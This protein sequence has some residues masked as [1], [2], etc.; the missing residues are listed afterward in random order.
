MK[1]SYTVFSFLL[2]SFA[3]VLTY[4]VTSSTATLAFAMFLLFVGSVFTLLISG[5]AHKLLAL[6]LFNIV[7][8][9]YVLLA[10][11]HYLG[12]EADWSLFTNE[13]LDEYKFY[14]KSEENKHLPIRAI[15]VDSFVQRTHLEYGGYV[16]YISLLSSIA[17][18]YFDGNHLLLQ[19][20]GTAIFGILI[21]VVMFKMLAL[22]LDSRKAFYYTLV[23][24]LFSVFS[25]YSVSL[26]R[27]MQI[28]FFFM[29]GFYLILNDDVKNKFLSL[30]LMLVINFLIWQLR[31]EHGLFFSLMVLYFCFKVFK[32]NRL[33]LAPLGL[34]A[35]A[36]FFVV[37]LTYMG[38]ALNTVDRYTSWTQEKVEDKED[39]FGRYIYQLPPV[40]K[41]LGIVFNSQIQPFPSWLSVVSAENIYKFISGLLKVIYAFFWFIVMFS[42]VKWLVIER[43]FVLIKGELLVLSLI[44]LLF[45]LL[46]TSNMTVRRIMVFYPF[47]YLIYVYIREQLPGKYEAVSAIA[48]GTYFYFSLVLLY[49]IL[50]I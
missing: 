17:T 13:W 27:D 7:F 5:K 9:F 50:K 6:H 49:F 40:A 18:T 11:N 32:R 24:M 15:F 4:P 46:N 3:A 35:I 33:V 47:I 26:L 31:F 23:F 48:G 12:Y 39:S 22:Y 36:L 14:L 34:L 8:C 29:C 1:Q 2:A 28:A 30:V 16:F 44:C 43:K 42:L 10:I 45:L 25:T 41:E 21:S 37:S 38:E 19:F 20:L